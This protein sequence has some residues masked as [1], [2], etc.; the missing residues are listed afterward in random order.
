MM[1]KSLLA[2]A[3]ALALGFAGGATAQTTPRGD[4]VRGGPPVGT[5][6]DGSRPADGAIQ[7]GTILPGEVGGAPTS[8]RGPTTPPG[9][10]LDRCEELTGTLR[11]Q[12]LL[13]AQGASTGGT[14]EP[15]AAT[16]SAGE[17]DGGLRTDPPP[18]VPR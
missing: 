14:R 7:G 18:Q 5:S 17:R 2:A 9:R 11:E 10:T 12:C 15:D 4:E 1:N 3:M 8:G 16:G 13:K 6:A